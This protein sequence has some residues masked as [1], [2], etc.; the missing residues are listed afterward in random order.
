MIK[1]D[2]NKDPR[3][4]DI[5][6]VILAGG[7]NTRIQLEKSLIKIKGD[8]IIDIQIEKLES[9]FEE[10]IIVT[11]KEDIIMKFPHLKIIADEFHDCGPLAGIHSALKHSNAEAIFVFACDMPFLSTKIIRKQIAAF[12][13]A[14]FDVLVPKHSDGIEPLHAIYSKSSLY[15]LTQCLYQKKYSVRSFYNKVK[16]NYLEFNNMEIIRFFNINT[17]ADLKKII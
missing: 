15:Y 5:S 10:I 17:H 3:I 4:R 11:Q 1:Y 7:K 13:K 16:V 14:K 2:L 12:N 6:A 8:H 9:I